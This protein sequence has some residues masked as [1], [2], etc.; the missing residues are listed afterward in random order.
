MSDSDD[1]FDQG[2]LTRSMADWVSAWQWLARAEHIA[3]AARKVHENAIKH[4]LETHRR[5]R[6]IFKKAGKPLP[7]SED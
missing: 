6:E 1:E 5:M 7:E 3:L 2:C 4:E